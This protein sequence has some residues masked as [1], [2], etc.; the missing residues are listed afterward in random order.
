MSRMRRPVTALSAERGSSDVE[1]VDPSTSSVPQ[2]ASGSW[3]LPVGVT[4]W[5]RTTRPVI[6]DVPASPVAPA[7]PAAAPARTFTDSATTSPASAVTASARIVPSAEDEVPGCAVVV[8]VE[9]PMRST[10][11][12]AGNENAPPPLA[13]GGADS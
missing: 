4:A 5:P 11:P 7:G 9:A 3:T 1:R 6:V 12:S 2:S 13:V 10:D 8:A